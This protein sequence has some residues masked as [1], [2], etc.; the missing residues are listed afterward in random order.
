[1]E[2]GLGVPGLFNVIN[3]DILK[4]VEIQP[5]LHYKTSL[6]KSHCA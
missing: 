3:M 1:M 2:S 6:G 4:G 5:G